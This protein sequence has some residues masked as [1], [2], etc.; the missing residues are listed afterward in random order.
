M[1][2]RPYFLSV[3]N[4]GFYEEK[5][6]E[7]EY[8]SG[9]A[10]S[11]KRKSIASLHAAILEKNP[12]A[13]ILEVSRK[14]EHIL[15]TK[16]SAFNLTLS[17]SDGS[18]YPVENIFQSSKV[19]ENGGPFRDIL[20]KTP[21]EAKRDERLKSSG[22]LVCFNFSGFEWDL[23]PRSYF[24]DYVYINAIARNMELR[25]ELMEFDTFTDIE[26][27]PKVSFNCQARS[28]AIYVSLRKQNK[29]REYLS[30]RDKFREVYEQ[31]MPVFE[32]S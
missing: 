8:F 12:E 11:Q 10:I 24:Y 26:F 22:D 29:V 14:S 27:N 7:F 15:G 19:F 9:F 3:M 28:V 16:L 30:N 21:L 18:S 5:S 17:M 4:N 23:L 6:A 32:L 25:D 1:A 31:F 20:Y 13:K 2:T